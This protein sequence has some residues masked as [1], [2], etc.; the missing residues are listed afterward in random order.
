MTSTVFPGL[1]GRANAARRNLREVSSVGHILTLQLQ[2]EM[3][4]PCFGLV[5]SSPER[6]SDDELWVDLLA[7]QARGDAADFLH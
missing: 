2:F 6:P 4:A 1:G 7:R 5:C 3:G